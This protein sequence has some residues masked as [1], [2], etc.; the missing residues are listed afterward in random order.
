MKVVE[1]LRGR[2]YS[3]SEIVEYYYK[4]IENTVAIEVDNNVEGSIVYGIQI[5][6]ILIEK[7]GTQS[8]ESE[9]ID[10][11][12]CNLELVKEICRIM[13]K[14]LVAPIHL[15]DVLE[16]NISKVFRMDSKIKFIE[17]VV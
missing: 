3:L 4:V 8:I 5:D 14:N 11:I 12:S 2:E 16:D 10:I 9:K 15:L 17:K 6:K 1:E 13:H 7:D